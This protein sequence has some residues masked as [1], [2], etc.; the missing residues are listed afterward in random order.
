MAAAYVLAVSPIPSKNGETDAFP[1]ILRVAI[2]FACAPENVTVS[3][4]I[5]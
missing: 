2:S 5:I 3:Q 1:E 4:K